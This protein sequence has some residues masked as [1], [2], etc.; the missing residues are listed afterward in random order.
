MPQS[1]QGRSDDGGQKKGVSFFQQ[2]LEESSENAFFHNDVDDVS[3]NTDEK[4]KK[5]G[6]HADGAGYRVCAYVYGESFK[7]ALHDVHEDFYRICGH[8]YE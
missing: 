6:L 2:F 4:E 8:K 7:S 5:A 1:E 3:G